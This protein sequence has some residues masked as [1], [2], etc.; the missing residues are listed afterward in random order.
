MRLICSACGFRTG[1]EQ[2]REGV[3]PECGG[4]LRRM[5]GLAGLIDRWF[6][7]GEQRVSEIGHRHTQMIE[8]MWTSGN[9][10][11]ELYRIIQPRG[12][13]YSGFVS[14]ITQVVCRGINEGWVQVQIPPAPV[15]DDAA[16]QLTFLD[17]D[18][19]AEEVGKLFPQR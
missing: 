13:S 1:A 7:P 9:R 15:N 14:R 6:A 10:A 19:F 17:P 2:A 11:Q 18:R 3:C 16:Y 8:L 5:R 4:R 12:V